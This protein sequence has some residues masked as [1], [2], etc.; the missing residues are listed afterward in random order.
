VFHEALVYFYLKSGRRRSKQ[1]EIDNLTKYILILTMLFFLSGTAIGQSR[2]VSGVVRDQKGSAIAGASVTVNIAGKDLGATTD[3]SGRF[4]FSDLSASSGNVRVTAPG[5]SEFSGPLLNDEVEI[6]LEPS[7]LAA[8]V[9]VTRFESRLSDTPVSVVTLGGRDLV[10]TPAATLDDK[11]RQIPGFSLFRRSGSR[12]ANPTSQGVSLRGT[13]GSG[14]SRAAV[15]VDGFPLN[16]PFGGWIYWGRVPTVSIEGVEVLRGAAG[17]LSGQS[18][19]GGIVSAT[20]R[21]VSGEPSLAVEASYGSQETPLGSLFATAGT[22][23][24]KGSIAGEAFATDGFITVAESDRGVVDTPAGVN[25]FALVPTIEYSLRK[26]SRIFFQGEYFE[27]RRKNGTPLQTNDTK[28]ITGRAGADPGRTDFGEVKLRGWFTYQI[29]HQSFSAITTDRN[30]ES[31]TRLQTV[32]S[33]S[34]GSSIQWTRSF[35]TRGAVYAGAETR[36]VGGASDETA[37]AAGR[38]TSLIGS[39][40]REF[41]FGM[42]AGGSYSPFTRVVVSGGVRLDRW[43]EYSAYSSTRSLL[44]GAFSR[45][46]FPDRNETSINPRLSALFRWTKWLSLT[47]S[48]STAFRQPTLNE[49]YRSFRVGNVLT[50]ANENLEAE[51]AMSLESGFLVNGLNDRLYIR[52]IGFCTAIDQPVANVTLS[53]TPAL[54][55]RQRQNLGATRS[56]GFEADSEWRMRRDLQFSAGYLFVD[57]RVTN[58]PADTTLEGLRVPQVPHHQLTFQAK[59]R[60]PKIA[61]LT[62]QLRVAD[63]QFD[64]DQN[65]FELQGFATLDLGASRSVGRHVELFAAVENV[66]HTTIEA[67]R[68]PV[69]TITGP[70][71]VRAGVRFRLGKTDR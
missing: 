45:T 64:D 39:G 14:A 25:R 43:S 65:Q 62:A 53:S 61:D 47:G 56:C 67:G 26:N 54:I 36:L 66:F 4:Q 42:F 63:S 32:P 70:R 46:S 22:K 12:T 5:F 28:I 34:F 60:N 41:T 11:L 18:A 33:S 29:Y 37:F 21:S 69:L 6:V 10:T 57:A 71:T 7:P 44:N 51:K 9:T 68:T 50:L 1:V 27:E 16:D 49:L 31:L 19:I 2:T 17:D 48:F 13:G 40:G 59:Y 30:S 52:G 58:F 8:R 24:W 55:T 20:A 35:S 15:T 38:A 23:Q 3:E